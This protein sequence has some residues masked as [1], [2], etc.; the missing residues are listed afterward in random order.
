MVVFPG[1]IIVFIL[2]LAFLWGV[3]YF[4]LKDGF[5]G[6]SPGK[7]LVGLLVVDLKK[8]S[9]GGLGLSALR[10]LINMVLCFIPYVGWL[11]EPVMAIAHE[12]GQRLGDLAAG[13]QV[14][15]KSIYLGGKKET[16]PQQAEMP[17]ASS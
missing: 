7:R 13:S 1:I 9:P 11:I 15:E 3:L 14:V 16:E 2:F 10:N 17:E 12:K 4:L 6:A 8:D 5:Q